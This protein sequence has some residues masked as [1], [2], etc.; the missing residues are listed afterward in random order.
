MNLDRNK[1]ARQ[2][3]TQAIA[4]DPRLPAAQEALGYCLF[5]MREFAAAET[6]YEGVLA[7]D[8]KSARAHAG[9]GSIN[10]IHYIED[11]TQLD[12]RDRALEHWHRSL[13]ISP[14]QPRIQS[15]IMQYSVPTNDPER[16]LLKT[17]K[18]KGPE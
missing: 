12:R 2:T 4:M 11:K 15:L 13:E 1:L 18:E 10:M 7:L 8:P 6:A 16:E 5:K 17:N 9:L 14:N 3:L